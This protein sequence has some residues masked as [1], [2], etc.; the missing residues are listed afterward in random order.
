[1]RRGKS[2]LRVSRNKRL[3]RDHIFSLTY[4][5]D[6]VQVVSKNFIKQYLRD[7]EGFNELLAKDTIVFQKMEDTSYKLKFTR[8]GAS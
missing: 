2:V 7:F 1:M 3:L 6:V 5:L 4:L 8:G